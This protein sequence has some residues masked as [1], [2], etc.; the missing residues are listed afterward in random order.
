M[1]ERANPFG[2]LNDFAPAKPKPTSQTTKAAAD[3]VAAE[4]N[5]P[6]RQAAK[7]AEQPGPRQQRRHRTG[8]NQ[9]INIKAT[10]ETVAQFNRLV[11]ELGVTQ[12]EVLERAL[13]A[14]EATK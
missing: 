7:P 14:L 3:Q 12:G 10:A 1:T 13:K 2:D 6:S 4:N 8:R 9:Q 11:D 5:F